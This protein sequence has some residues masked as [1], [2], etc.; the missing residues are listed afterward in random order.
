MKQP[1]KGSG[2]GRRDS[3]GGVTK[4]TLTPGKKEWR[5]KGVL[6]EYR[7]LFVE[8]SRGADRVRKTRDETTHEG[9]KTVHDTG[10]VDTTSGVLTL[11]F[12]PHKINSG[13][14][15][16][17]PKL[18]TQEFI[19]VFQTPK[20]L[21]TTHAPPKCPWCDRRPEPSRGVSKPRCSTRN[22][23]IPTEN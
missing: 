10:S 3:K 21:R 1:E 6:H 11:P 5:N 8:E 15:R 22:V 20:P 4:T 23:R 2:G 18:E 16:S 19:G 14:F 7:D 17:S 13:E 12:F 9:R